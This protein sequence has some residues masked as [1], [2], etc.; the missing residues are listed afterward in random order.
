MRL[1]HDFFWVF[2][3]RRIADHPYRLYIG[4]LIKIR[5]HN[6]FIRTKLNQ[7]TTNSFYF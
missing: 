7:T 1:E 6:S 4:S 5:E 2:L 3:Y